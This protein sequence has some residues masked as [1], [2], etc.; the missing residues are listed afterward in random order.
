MSY[1]AALIDN[2]YYVRWQEPEHRDP[3]RIFREVAQ[4]SRSLGQPVIYIAVSPEHSPAPD[5]ETRQEMVRIFEQLSQLC[6]SVHL[7]YEAKG[8]KASIKRNVMT[9]I[10]LASK[11]FEK[12]KVHKSEEEALASLEDRVDLPRFRQRVLSLGLTR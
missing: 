3:N 5:K 6:L 2:V 4:A 11:K 10:L 12:V 8:F 9:G 7:V 1:K